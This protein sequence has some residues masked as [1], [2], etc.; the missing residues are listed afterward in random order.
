MTNLPRIMVSMPPDIEK[1]IDDMRK[2]PGNE[3][4]PKSKLLCQL[5]RKG[6]EH[7]EDAKALPNSDT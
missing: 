4:V 6:M 3:R 2:E 7:Q 1:A 5:V